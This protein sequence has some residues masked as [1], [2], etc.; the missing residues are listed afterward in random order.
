MG[1]EKKKKK[2]KKN[3]RGGVRFQFSDNFGPSTN[4]V[5]LPRWTDYDC[6]ACVLSLLNIINCEEALLISLLMPWG[7][8][9]DQFAT[10]CKTMQPSLSFWWKPI[11]NPDVLR[12]QIAVGQTA[13][14]FLEKGQERVGHY[15]LI[16]R[17]PD[18]QNTKYEFVFIDSQ[19][20]NIVYPLDE[21]FIAYNGG[22]VTAKKARALTTIQI[23]QSNDPKVNFPD[24]DAGTSSV[25]FVGEKPG[26]A[27]S[28][29]RQPKFKVKELNQAYHQRNIVC[30]NAKPCLK[31]IRV[32]ARLE[33]KKKG[34]I[35][36]SERFKKIITYFKQKHDS[37]TA[38]TRQLL[39]QDTEKELHK[40]IQ[41]IIDQGIAT[42]QE[43]AKNGQS[44]Y[45]DREKGLKSCQ[46]LLEQSSR[47]HEWARRQSW[48]PPANPPQMEGG[49][50]TRR[51]RRKKK[52]KYKKKKEK[53]KEHSDVRKVRVIY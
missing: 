3:N 31:S 12:N 23:L 50:W 17:T 44:Y 5:S 33:T 20:P 22:N 52:T 43:V 26:Q 14:I 24:K 6:A 30:L 48:A 45:G 34:A 51:R 49:A 29:N 15:A 35:D 7:L 41:K 27:Q 13:I 10:L 47:V 25:F 32:L 2:K 9:L 8:S 4:R 36:E 19:A 46:A 18:P 37:G 42:D 28:W 40:M 11:A 21:Y 38:P 53:K 16:T 1:R 39:L